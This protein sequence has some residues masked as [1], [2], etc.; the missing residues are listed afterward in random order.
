M[1]ILYYT[2]YIYIYT[3]FPCVY[4]AMFYNIFVC[5]NLYIYIYIYIVIYVHIFM[6]IHD[7]YDTSCPAVSTTGT[8]P[9]TRHLR[10][11]P[12]H[13]EAAAGDQ[14]H[15]GPFQIVSGEGLVYNILS[16]YLYIISIY[17]YIYYIYTII[18]TKY[19]IIYLYISC[20]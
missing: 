19:H 5:I 8:W 17:I 3:H 13:R 1:C 10:Q 16:L 18:H 20:I 11:P 2:T 14:P 7:S 4:S 12:G 9:Y 15:A 6:I